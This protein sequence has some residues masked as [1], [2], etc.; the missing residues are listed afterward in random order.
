MNNLGQGLAIMIMGLGITF[1]ALGLFIGLILLLERFF[2]PKAQTGAE[3]F[4]TLPAVSQFERD[5][6]DE[7]IAAA[8][9]I[10]LA[11]LYSYELCRSDLGVDLEKGRSPWWVGGRLNQIPLGSLSLQGRN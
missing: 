11:H 2:P 3:A 10:A 6:T 9:A 7:E 5:T 4:E 8:I 1:T